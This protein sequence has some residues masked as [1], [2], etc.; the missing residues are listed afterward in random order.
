MTATTYSV[1]S[2]TKLLSRQN[3]EPFLGPQCLF[4]TNVLLWYL[5]GDERLSKEARESIESQSG[6]KY[7]SI[8]SAWEVAIKISL[9]KL[10][11]EGGTTLFWRTFVEGGFMGLPITIESVEA[12][13]SLPFHHRD[14][15]DRLL[16]ATALTHGLELVATDDIFSKYSKEDV[17]GGTSSLHALNTY[18]PEAVKTDLKS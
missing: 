13:E 9:G 17:L 7:I 8:V 5:S 4:D 1:I 3:K 10:K 6:R 16:I 12:V 11:V 2:D 15:F 14:P 18:V